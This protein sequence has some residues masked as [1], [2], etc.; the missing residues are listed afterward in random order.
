MITGFQAALGV[1]DVRGGAV[2]RS[3]TPREKRYVIS[4]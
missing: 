1:R 4:S 2:S 3:W